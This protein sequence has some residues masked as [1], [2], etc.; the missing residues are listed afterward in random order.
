M[1]P[2]QPER[3]D[4]FSTGQDYVFNIYSIAPGS[5]TYSTV[6]PF[7]DSLVKLIQRLFAKASLFTD[8]RRLGTPERCLA[9]L[10]TSEIA[11]WAAKVRDSPQRIRVIAD[12]QTSRMLPTP[13]K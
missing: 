13:D 12:T 2:F 4:G 9:R 6:S 8:S 3:S 10:A 5:I 1:G 11:A 7:V